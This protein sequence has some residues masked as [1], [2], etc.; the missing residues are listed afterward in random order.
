[1]TVTILFILVLRPGTGNCLYQSHSL[2]VDFTI[3]L[4]F[5]LKWNRNYNDALNTVALLN[6]KCLSCMRLGMRS[7]LA[8]L[9]WSFS[10]TC[11]ITWWWTFMT[12]PCSDW[13]HLCQSTS[14]AC[15]VSGSDIIF[16]KCH[17]HIFIYL[18]AFTIVI[19]D[20][21]WQGRARLW[22]VTQS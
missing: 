7:Y 19:F 15:L 9:K 21:N 18:D 3:Q 8:A 17:C 16:P 20:D 10:Q 2:K 22:L 13:F 12:W 5:N 14:S 1:M 4:Y 6:N 11:V